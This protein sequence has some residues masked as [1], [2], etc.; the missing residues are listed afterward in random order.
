MKKIIN[1]L[2]QITFP[3]LLMT[4]NI[5]SMDEPPKKTS[6]TPKFKTWLVAVGEIVTGN[7][8]MS[9]LSAPQQQIDPFSFTNL[10]PEIQTTIIT[11]LLEG[12]NA[13]TLAEAAKSISS[14][15][16]VNHDLNELINNPAFCLQIIKS[17]SKRFNYSNFDVCA[18]LQIKQAKMQCDIQQQLF[19]LCIEPQ[20]NEQLFTILLFNGADR[21]FTYMHKGTIVTPLMF[22]CLNNSQ[23]VRYLIASGVDVNQSNSN[24]LTAL[25]LTA[26]TRNTFAMGQLIEDKNID[27]NQQDNFGDTALIFAINNKNLRFIKALLA[28]GANPN[29]PNAD[30]A[31]QAAQDTHDPE[32]INTFKEV[33]Q[34]RKNT[35]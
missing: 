35:P 5:V 2:K 1:A 31:M 10:L 9:L 25:M 34:I 14:L 20:P 17:L 12:R 13:K 23:M 3:L 6:Q 32:F 18:V 28:K 22:A 26:Q 15:A 24:G 7:A 8:P 33:M 19:D 29:L 4:L 27:I 30:A 11:I 21:S 16:Q